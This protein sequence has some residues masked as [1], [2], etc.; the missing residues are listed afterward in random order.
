MSYWGYVM[1]SLMT[2]DRDAAERRV[3]RRRR[4]KRAREEAVLAA[5]DDAL[6]K[7]LDTQLALSRQPAPAAKSNAAS[8]GPIRHRA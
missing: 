5:L 1:Q 6:P 7:D 8:P 2:E 3:H 4:S